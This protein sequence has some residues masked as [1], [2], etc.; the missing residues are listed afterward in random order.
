MDVNVYYFL[1]FD[2]SNVSKLFQVHEA[3]YMVFKGKFL[4]VLRFNSSSLCVY[5]NL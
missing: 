4:I 3:N 1:Q 2:V 5:G